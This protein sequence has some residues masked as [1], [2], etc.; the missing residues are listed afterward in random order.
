MCLSPCARLMELSLLQHPAVKSSNPKGSLEHKDLSSGKGQAQQPGTGRNS[1]SPDK[2]GRGW[3]RRSDDGKSA[4]SRGSRALLHGQ[5]CAEDSS[6]LSW[7]NFHNTDSSAES[8]REHCWGVTPERLTLSILYWGLFFL[9]CGVCDSGK[10]SC[11]GTVAMV[12]QIWWNHTRKKENT[13]RCW[14]TGE[15]ESSHWRKNNTTEVAVSVRNSA[16]LGHN[17]SSNSGS[18]LCVFTRQA[19]GPLQT[20]GRL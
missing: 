5:Q 17:Q 2:D 6:A 15:T 3:R 14:G 18:K 16:C 12:N 13:K 1:S 7:S 8:Q 9:D 20:G 19:P 11:C 10:G 4:P